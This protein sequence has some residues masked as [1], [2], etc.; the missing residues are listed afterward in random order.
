MNKKQLLILVVSIV[1]VLVLTAVFAFFYLK[2]SI[3]RCKDD[4]CIKK[5]V[6]LKNF[7]P[8]DC[9]KAPSLQLQNKCYY[10]YEVENK[11]V[12]KIEPT[13]YCSS[14]KDID[15]TLECFSKC[16]EKDEKIY[17]PVDNYTSVIH[18][19]INILDTQICEKIIDAPEL[20]EECLSGVALTE[21][22]INEK[23]SALCSE[24]KSFKVS[25]FARRTCL[26]KVL[27]E[28]KGI[29]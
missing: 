13:K 3:E 27:L 14:I 17:F 15:L 23:S 21:K 19:S 24:D 8:E 28:L 4:D 12:L 1:I 22:A 6:L 11:E 5:S 10:T 16:K 18:K 7:N 25:D 2:P 26:I 9:S 20:K 29:Q